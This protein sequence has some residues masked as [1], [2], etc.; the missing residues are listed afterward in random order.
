MGAATPDYSNE[1]GALF[2]FRS[3][4][5]F[6]IL[7]IVIAIAISFSVTNRKFAIA[8]RL[9]CHLR[10]IDTRSSNVAAYSSAAAAFED[11]HDVQGGFATPAER[12]ETVVAPLKQV[13][14]PIL[15]LF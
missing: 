3:P 8:N 10:F 12:I 11:L 13:R 2:A 6:L 5:V 7:L 15:F 4:S 1:H 9:R 14:F